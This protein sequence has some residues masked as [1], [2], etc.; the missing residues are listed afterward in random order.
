MCEN[1]KGLKETYNIL[2]KKTYNNCLLET[3][4]F[5]VVPDNYPVADYHILIIPKEHYMSY[6]TLEDNKSFELDAIVKT[7][8]TITKSSNFIL[9]EH[10]SNNVKNIQK[11]CGNSLYHA[12]LHFIP[13]VQLNKDKII[14]ICTSKKEG[15]ELELIEKESFQDCIYYKKKEQLILDFLKKDLPTREPYLFCCYSSLTGGTLCVQDSKIKGNSA[16]SQFFRRI[17]AEICNPDIEKPFFNWKKEED[18]KFSHEIRE[19]RIEQIKEKFIDKEKIS[20]TFLEIMKLS[21]SQISGIK[22]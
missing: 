14:E 5:Y 12:H 1:G 7:I 3:E 18:V 10:G 13:D 16:P 20:S 4:N 8:S 15:Q 22:K 2:Y 11:P 17:F 21:L 19:R 6:S 9:F